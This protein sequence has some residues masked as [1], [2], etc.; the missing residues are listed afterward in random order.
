VRLVGG[1]VSRIDPNGENE[2]GGS[3]KCKV[4]VETERTEDML[5]GMNASVRMTVDSRDNVLLLPLAA[6]SEENGK[7][8]VYSSYDEE[9]DLLGTPVEVTTGWSDGEMVEIV[10]G[11]EAGDSC[12]Y[13]YA[14]TI[15]YAFQQ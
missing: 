14:D 5:T 4:L 8:S 15:R 3:T 9:N 13:R 1:E 12:F 2:D 11:L 10:S 7:I 6:I